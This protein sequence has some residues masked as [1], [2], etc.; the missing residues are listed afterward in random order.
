MVCLTKDLPNLFKFQ[1]EHASQVD[2]FEIISVYQDVEGKTNTIAKMDEVLKP[3]IKHVWGGKT[4]PFLTIVE[5]TYRTAES[6]GLLGYGEV[7]LINPEGKLVAG[8]LE[9]LR[10]IL[11]RK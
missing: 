11:A 2:Q 3:V 9:T 1:Q 7:A 10:G 5:S 4:P 8:D 6:W